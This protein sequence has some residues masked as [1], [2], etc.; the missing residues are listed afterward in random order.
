M[1]EVFYND[2]L[3]KVHGGWIGKCIGGAVGAY[4]ENNR[5]LLNFT[6]DNIFPGEVPFND[7]LDLQLLWLDVLERKGSKINSRDLADAWVKSVWYA[8]NEY[9]YFNKNYRLGVEPPTSGVF[10]NSF[11]RDSMGCPIRSEI[12]GFICPGTPAAAIDYVTKDG[13]LDHGMNAVYAEQ[14]FAVMEAEAFFEHDL[15]ALLEKGLAYVPA[16]T[17]LHACIRFVIRQ[18][19]SGSSWV[20]T[21]QEMLKQFGSPDASHSVQ[22]IG[23]TVLALL[24]GNG[25]FGETMLIAV[26]SGYDT[27]CTAATAGAILGQMTGA[28]A[29]PDDWLNKIGEDFVIGINLTRPSLSI[30]N[31]AIDTCRAGLSLQRDGLLDVRIVRIPEDVHPSLPPRPADPELEIEVVYEDK[32]AIG[33]NETVKVKAVV[34]NRTDHAQTGSFM[35]KLPRH[36]QS[37]LAHAELRIQPHSSQEVPMRF[38]V[39]EDCRQ[40]AQKNIVAL[41]WTGNDGKKAEKSFGIIGAARLKAIGPF[42]DTFDSKAHKE[43]P[44]KNGRPQGKFHYNNFV[45]LQKAYI[46]ESFRQLDDY[47]AV[48]I[49]AHEDKLPLNELFRHKGQSCVY[50][51]H[52]L[53]SPEDREMKI[54]IGNND[55]Y[56]IWLDGK[57][58]AEDSEHTMW[59]PFNAEVAAKFNKGVNRLV[60][61]VVRTDSNFEFSYGFCG[62]SAGFEAAPVHWFVDLASKIAD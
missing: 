1:R 52:D 17:E 8:P 5:D 20:Q 24:F 29:F 31:L 56:K 9:G 13:T 53:V 46:D 33:I 62:D 12:W 21:R 19:R 35:V 59:T 6:V 47:E 25:D 50:L 36:L 4:M 55:G 15:F 27:D 57:L 39:A 51:V 58:I 60:F 22:N 43:S 7:D 45:N 40:L 2:Y 32:P 16:D 34:H 48:W 37:D 44:Y 3:D 54:I 11:F 18:Y 28:N 38:R 14:F 23:L 49:N 61:K 26:N 42:W 41:Q 10:N 30:R